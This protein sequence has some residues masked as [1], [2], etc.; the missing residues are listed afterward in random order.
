MAEVPGFEKMSNNER[1]ELERVRAQS[2]VSGWAWS[3]SPGSRR[4]RSGEQI[5]LVDHDF[6]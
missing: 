5:L 4:A 2:E 6:L 1:D 3:K